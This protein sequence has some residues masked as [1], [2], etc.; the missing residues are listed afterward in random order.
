MKAKPHPIVHLKF[1]CTVE[2]VMGSLHEIL[3]LQ[4]SF[5]YLQQELIT[6]F[7]LSVNRNHS[8]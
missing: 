5:P 3:G 7:E 1:Q 2:L 6:P 4:Q 8:C